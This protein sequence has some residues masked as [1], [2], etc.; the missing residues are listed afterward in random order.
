MMP[1]PGREKA[2][3]RAAFHVENL[4]RKTLLDLILLRKTQCRDVFDSKY[5]NILQEF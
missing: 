4:V 2:A 5:K 1:S 3:A